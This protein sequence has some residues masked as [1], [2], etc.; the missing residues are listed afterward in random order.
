MEI[1]ETKE[2]SVLEDIIRSIKHTNIENRIV[3][4]PSKTRMTASKKCT[5]AFSNFVITFKVNIH[6]FHHQGID[7]TPSYDLVSKD[8]TI[9]LI[10]VRRIDT[11]EEVEL[12][13]AERRI[14]VEEIAQHLFFDVYVTKES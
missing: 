5:R 6:S 4:V 8:C 3:D 13:P 11:N 9:Q 14:I 2:I 12:L 10:E 7:G 1:I